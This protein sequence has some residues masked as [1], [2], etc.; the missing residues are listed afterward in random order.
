MASLRSLF[1]LVAAA[2][3]TEEQV[4]VSDFFV[5]KQASTIGNSINSVSFRLKGAIQELQCSAGEIAYPEPVKLLSCSDSKYAFTLW[6]G[7]SHDDFRV[8]I[9]HDV[10]DRKANL[11]GAANVATVCDEND[12][13]NASDVI[14]RQINPVSFSIDGPIAWTFAEKAFASFNRWTSRPEI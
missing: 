12:V 4:T 9:H 11:R 13:D 3:A 7:T 10:G 8:I 14:C 6:P 5:H 2:L 1:S